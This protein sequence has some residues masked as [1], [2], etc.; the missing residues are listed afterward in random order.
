[1]LKRLRLIGTLIVIASSISFSAKAQD[2]EWYCK[3]PEMNR[4][5]L[6]NDPD[7][8]AR[9]AELRAFIDHYK[10]SQPK[11]DQVYIIPVVFHVVH[12]YGPENLSLEQ[13][14]DQIRILNEDYRLMNPDTVMIVNEFK[15]IATDCQIEFRLAKKDP[16]GNCST[17]VTR[18]VS[19]ATTLAGENVKEIAPSWPRSMYLNVW[20]VKS[21]GGGAAG[22][23]FYPGTVGDGQDGILINYKY[24]ASIGTGSNSRSRTLTH[25]IGHYLNLAH[26][27]GSTNEPGLPGNCGMDDGIEDTPN[28]IGHTS[29]ALNAV[30]CGS[31]DNVQN[32][33]DYSYCCKMFTHG[34]GTE[35]RAVLNS[36]IAERN[37]LW[38][39]SNLIATGV[40]GEYDETCPPVADFDADIIRA[41]EGVQVQFSD[42]SYGTD[43]IDARNWTFEGGFPSS[44]TEANPVVEYSLAG[45]FDVSLTVENESGTN[46]YTKEAFISV[47]SIDNA[48]DFPIDFDFENPD[49]PDVST[50]N[51]NDFYFIESS[52]DHWELSNSVSVS[53]DHAMQIE[54]QNNRTNSNNAFVT[55]MIAVDSL[56]FPVEVSF[57]VAYAQKDK[58]SSD[59]LRIYV[60]DNCGQTW[61]LHYYQSGV[62]LQ[63]TD[64]YYPFGTFIPEDNEWGTNSFVINPTSFSDAESLRLKFEASS[65][66]GNM[67]Y[68]DDISV[69]QSSSLATNRF[70]NKFE[71]YPNPF[72]QSLEI[73]SASAYPAQLTFRDI[74]GR[75]TGVTTIPA[76]TSMHVEDM[77]PETSGLYLIQVNSEE[78]RATY[79]IQ[80]K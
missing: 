29:C 41:C 4:K 30:S 64:N 37:E 2:T 40:N 15:Q 11:D 22:Y 59:R 1:M 74:T 32:Y 73:H 44:S 56:D 36:S 35:M 53:G 60:S 39:E 80:R 55:P 6:E 49:F 19:E 23:S 58:F 50:G 48:L 57:Q 26:P 78:G 18:T 17:G 25:E 38:Q 71:I 70:R 12:N 27:W 63:T 69:H 42:L 72:D 16:E 33:M 28:T 67:L 21:I 20:V 14:K 5:I 7:A 10:Q 13:I 31:L 47:Y 77:L 52:Y 76:N 46:E 68:I 62:T 65:D 24:V 75:I 66:G 9:R 43:N 3:T 45:D 61:H 51:N 54:N 79:K 8:R 34:Q